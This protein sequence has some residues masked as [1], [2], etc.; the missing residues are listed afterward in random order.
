MVAVEQEVLLRVVLFQAS[1]PSGLGD[2]LAFSNCP[3]R[4][5]VPNPSAK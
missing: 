2:Y 3:A 5:V 1:A 4:T